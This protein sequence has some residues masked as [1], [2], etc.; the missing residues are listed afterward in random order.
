MSGGVFTRVFDDDGAVVRFSDAD[1][2]A[3]IKKKFASEGLRVETY[4]GTKKDYERTAKRPNKRETANPCPKCAEMFTKLGI[5]GSVMA[6]NRKGK[7]HTTPW[8]GHSTY[9]P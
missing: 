1:V 4:E 3:E 6:H 7:G 2:Q 5:E 9:R 8:D